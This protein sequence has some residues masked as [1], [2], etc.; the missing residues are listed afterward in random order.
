MVSG[1]YA[2]SFTKGVTTTT[3]RNF[4]KL[5]INLL[6]IALATNNV[7]Y[8][9]VAITK[10]CDNLQRVYVAGKLLNVEKAVR[11]NVR[12]IVKYYQKKWPV[13]KI[14]RLLPKDPLAKVPMLMEKTFQI[15][16]KYH[17]TYKNK[18]ILLDWVDWESTFD[19]KH[20]HQVFLLLNL[21]MKLI[22]DTEGKIMVMLFTARHPDDKEP[23]NNFFHIIPACG[24]PASANCVGWCD[25]KETKPD[26]KKCST[27][28]EKKKKLSGTKRKKEIQGN[29][30][31]KD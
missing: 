15:I 6:S 13:N 23:W 3:N 17:T 1:S 16:E 9:S 4:F 19:M 24:R 31:K 11:H 29:K 8:P 5:L 26:V 7:Q 2:A 18:G 22:F 20:P 21:C 28:K 30:G 25:G 27:G 14:E 12:T 10:K